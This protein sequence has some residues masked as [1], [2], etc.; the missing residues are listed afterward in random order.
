MDYRGN[1]MRCK[2]KG[3]MAQRAVQLLKA[4]RPDFINMA[5]GKKTRVPA[6]PFD[7]PLCWR[8]HLTIHL[9]V[10]AKI[11]LHAHIRW[12]HV[13]MQADRAGELLYNSEAGM[14]QAGG[15]RG[16]QDKET[17]IE[18]CVDAGISTGRSTQT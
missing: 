14:L 18:M 3:K 16:G 13:R 6:V 15:M 5:A 7:V 8:S 9:H 2:L 10:K 11:N 4:T 17:Q 12:K 1:K